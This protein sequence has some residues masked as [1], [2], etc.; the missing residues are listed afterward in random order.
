LIP[1]Q[2]LTKKLARQRQIVSLAVELTIRVE[3]RSD[4]VQIGD[5][6]TPHK[7]IPRLHGC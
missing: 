3:Q 1:L 2:S 5:R 6:C 7:N 4:P